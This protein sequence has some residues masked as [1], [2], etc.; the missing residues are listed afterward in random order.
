[1]YS[2]HN[3]IQ[4]GKQKHCKFPEINTAKLLFSKHLP[5]CLLGRSSILRIHEVVPCLTILH[6][7]NSFLFEKDPTCRYGYSN[8]IIECFRFGSATYWRNS[9]V[10][11]HFDRTV[12]CFTLRVL[13]SLTCQAST[14]ARAS[15]HRNTRAKIFVEELTYG[16]REPARSRRTLANVELGAV[17]RIDTQ[18]HHARRTHLWNTSTKQ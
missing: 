1:M 5:S 10:I 12:A 6:Y 4:C 13:H 16:T 15:V 7:F 9:F 8:Q 18:G 3:I 2:N 17:T 14:A 11:L